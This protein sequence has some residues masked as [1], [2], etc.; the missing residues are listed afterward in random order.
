MLQKIDEMISSGKSYT[1]ETTLASKS[2]VGIIKQA[3]QCGYHCTL[4]YFWLESPV[5]AIERVKARVEAGGHS[6]PPDVIVRRYY[7]GLK[8]L[9]GLYM[10]LVNSW[11]IY[12]NSKAIRELIAEGGSDQME[13][14]KI[15]TFTK[16]TESSK[17]IDHG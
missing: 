13:I 4:L 8:N 2:L 12:D 11:M 14:K 5:Q 7:S 17:D 9:R 6:I 3:K 15:S 1:I 10:P 16:V